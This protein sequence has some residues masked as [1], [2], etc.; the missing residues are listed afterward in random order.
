[1][2]AKEDRAEDQGGDK[3]TKASCSGYPHVERTVGTGAKGRHVPVFWFLSMRG[4]VLSSNELPP[5]VR[6]VLLRFTWGRQ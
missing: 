2:A 5:W 1:M 6:E 4:K 3:G